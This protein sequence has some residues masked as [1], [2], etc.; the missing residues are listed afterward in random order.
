ML[1]V[2]LVYDQILFRPLVA[3]ADRLRFEQAPGIAAPQSWGL[4]ILHRSRIVDRIKRPCAVLWRRLLL[5]RHPDNVEA[6]KRAPR[7]R[8]GW[9][10]FQLGLIVFALTAFALWQER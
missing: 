7:T 1:V 6:V 5:P 2:I 9:I 8:P 4:A 10:A 3:W